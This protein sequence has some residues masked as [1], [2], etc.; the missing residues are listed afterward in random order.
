MT[1]DTRHATSYST[2]ASTSRFGSLDG[3]RAV[4][5]LGVIWHHTLSNAIAQP[6]A[7][8]G[9][10]GVTLF[11]VISGFLIVTL[12]LRSQDSSIG[13]SLPRF[14]WRRCLR[15]FP[16]YYGTLLIYIVLVGLTDHSDSGHQ[17]FRNLPFFSTFTTNWFVLAQGDRTVFLFSWSLAAEEQFY[18]LWPLVEVLIRSR[19]IKLTLLGLLAVVSQ[20]LMARHY[21]LNGSGTLPERM[22]YNVPL[23][24]LAG[25]LMAHLFHKPRSFRICYAVLGQ[26]GS[27]V[28]ALVGAMAGLA[29]DL[30]LGYPGE[31]VV[32]LM[33]SLLIGACVIREDNDLAVL[34]HWRPLVWMGTVSYGMYML[35][36]LGVNVARRAQALLHVH[37]AGAD[38]VG[39]VVMALALAS[40]SFMFF[41][42]PILRLKNAFPLAATAGRPASADGV[43]GANYEPGRTRG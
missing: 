2:Y 10:R 39:G 40:V 23:A 21:S 24:I 19:W 31:P 32:T 42:R 12:L 14:W 15:I 28:G 27:A 34:L 18:L 36:M 29:L 13:F 4:A 38:F 16:V 43:R 9:F 41:E 17:F 1:L 11:F 22:L 6:L 26:R 37:Y 30:P 35:H 25:T 3:W 33:L 20:Y 7:H 8:E 5:I